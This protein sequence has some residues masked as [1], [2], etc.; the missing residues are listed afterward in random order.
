MSRLYFLLFIFLSVPGLASAQFLFKDVTGPAG[1][2]MRASA[3]GDIGGGVVIFDFDGD[4]W[5]DIYMAGGLDS[6]KL[7][8]NMH[9]GTFKNIATPEFAVHDTTFPPGSKGFRTYPHGGIAFDYDNDGFPDIYSVCENRDIL[10]HNNGDGTFSDRTQSAQLNFPLDANESNSATFGDFNG[11]GFND[12]YVARWIDLN[13]FISDGEGNYVG[14]AHQGFPDWFYVNNGD[15]TFTDRA[16]ELN[17]GNDTGCGN[18]AVFFDYDRDGDLDLLVGNDFGVELLPKRVYKNMLMETGKA[19]FVRVDTLIGMQSHLFSMGIGPNDYDRDGN[20]DFYETTIGP[21]KLMKNNGDGTFSD[22]AKTTLPSFNG[23]ERGGSGYYTTSWTALMADYDNDG[24]EDGFIVHGYEGGIAPWI[25][26]QNQMDTSIFLYNNNGIFE[27][28]T[29]LAMSGQYLNMK[30]RGAAYFD[31][32]HDGKLDLCIGSLALNP[33]VITPDFRILQNITPDR[34]D[35]SNHWLEMRFTAKRTAKEGIG[36]IADVWAG[37]IRHSRQVSTGGGFGSQN[38]LM[39]HVGL[40][41]YSKIDSLNVFWPADKYLHRQIDHYYNLPVDTLLYF[42]E[43]TGAESVASAPSPGQVNIF[44][45]PARNYLNVQNLTPAVTKRFEIYDILGTRQ[46]DVNGSESAF[47]L[48][49]G[50]L[51]P[52][53]YVL[54]I[55]TNGNTVTKQFIKE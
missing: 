41:K 10:W 28:Y 9:D 33:S 34:A 42:T 17:V 5:D 45:S 49:V 2:Y 27:D 30:A 48:S 32:N 21:E 53:C 52:G 38:S 12:F 23:F 26:N 29:D 35:N 25:S 40:G 18:V 19:Y 8:L 15:G 14:Y 4:G 50:N 16:A 3:V 36:T 43:Q 37:G 20:F 22:V 54:R 6:D 51:K 39:Q 11:D 7:Y 31:F 1:I 44:P 55:T 47:S 46:I 24:W 13:R